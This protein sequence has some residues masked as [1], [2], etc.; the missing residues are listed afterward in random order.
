MCFLSLV[1]LFQLW[2]C[3]MSEP[4]L[5]KVTCTI[6]LTFT[7]WNL[8]FMIVYPKLILCSLLSQYFIYFL[9]YLT[10]KINP[11][12]L[13]LSICP[14]LAILLLR[15]F[16]NKNVHVP[17]MQHKTSKIF[18]ENYMSFDPFVLMSFCPLYDIN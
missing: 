18:F 12:T 8:V 14:N 13:N 9:V 16:D 4:A 15:C 17:K 11:L 7:E 10:I 6:S 1:C 5:F 2:T 3:C